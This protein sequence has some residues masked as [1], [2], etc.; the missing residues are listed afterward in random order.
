M[1]GGC[2]CSVT[3]GSGSARLAIYSLSRLIASRGVE[4]SGSLPENAVNPSMGAPGAASMLRTVSGRD[5]EP[6]TPRDAR[7]R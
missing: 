1:A 6:S 2:G 3:R 4:G 5:P 7:L